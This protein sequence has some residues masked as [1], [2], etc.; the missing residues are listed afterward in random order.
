M[1][2]EN[3]ATLEYLLRRLA[4]LG[5]QLTGSLVGRIGINTEAVTSRGCVSGPH[6]STRCL[7]MLMYSIM[8]SCISS[9]SACRPVLVCNA[10]VIHVFNCC[11]TF[12]F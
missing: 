5:K 1:S 7:T 11:N 6:D 9:D 4:R 8:V 3:F 2:L 10:A 12:F